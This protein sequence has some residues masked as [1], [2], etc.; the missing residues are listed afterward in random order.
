MKLGKP[1]RILLNEKWDF[2]ASGRRERSYSESD[3]IIQYLG[4]V[5]TIAFVPENKL[6]IQREIPWITA[7]TID[8]RDFLLELMMIE[9]VLKSE[10]LTL[11]ELDLGDLNKIHELHSLPETDE[12]N[13]MGIP[14]NIG[15]TER[16]LADWIG[17]RELD[18]RMKYVFKVEDAANNF[19]GLIGLNMGTSNYRTAEVWYKLHKDFWNK[20]YGTEA[21]NR[22]LEFCFTDLKLHRIEAGCAVENHGSIRVL[23]KAAMIREGRKRKKLPIRGEW[24]DNYFYAILEEDFYNMNPR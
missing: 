10:R 20:G 23:E 22:L 9:H 3:Y 7:K 1:V 15:V 12:F 5:E 14:A 24:V 18:P 4:E 21:L 11:K 16:L 2:T 6:E 8:L 17:I 19:I 13:T